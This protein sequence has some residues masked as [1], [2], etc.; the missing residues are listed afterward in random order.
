MKS[1]RVFMLYLSSILISTVA[2]GSFAQGQGTWI[3]RAPM[4]TS[5]T[6]VAAAELG[7]RIY[8]IGGFGQ[9]GDLVEEYDPRVMTVGAGRFPSRSH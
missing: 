8:V 3:S 1:K 5:R 4:P 9:G 2:L 6:E 7:G